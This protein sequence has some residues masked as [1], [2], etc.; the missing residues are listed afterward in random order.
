MGSHFE[1]RSSGSRVLC[2][3]LES[4]S[5]GLKVVRSGFETRSIGSQ[6]VCILK[7]CPEGLE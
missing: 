2:C 4:R 7:H 1:A 5:K 6:V 3:C